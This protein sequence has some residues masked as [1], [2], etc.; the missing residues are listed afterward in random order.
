MRLSRR[1][2]RQGDPGGVV[3]LLSLEDGLA[4]RFLPSVVLRVL[5]AASILQWPGRDLLLAWM[6]RTAQKRAE[7]DA[8]ARRRSVLKSDDWLDRALPFEGR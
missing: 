7:A 8:F 6:L 5:R 2:G 3:T 4:R 1:C